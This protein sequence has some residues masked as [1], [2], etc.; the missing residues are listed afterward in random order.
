M[1]ASRICLSG[2]ELTAIN[3]AL[4]KIDVDETHF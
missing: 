3:A 1:G 4:A 2:D